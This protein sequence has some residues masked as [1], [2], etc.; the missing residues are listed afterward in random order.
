MYIYLQRWNKKKEA[1]KK[2]KKIMKKAASLDFN[3]VISWI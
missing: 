3:T 2:Y 1:G